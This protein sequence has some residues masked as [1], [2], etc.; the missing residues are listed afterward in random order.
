[1]QTNRIHDMYGTGKSPYEI[2]GVTLKSSVGELKRAYRAKA[3]ATHPDRNKSPN[4]GKEFIEITKAYEELSQRSEFKPDIRRFEKPICY[5]AN[6]TT[7]VHVGSE[8]LNIFLHDE[9]NIIIRGE[10]I[11]TYFN[12]KQI[13]LPLGNLID[14]VYL[15]VRYFS[16]RVELCPDSTREKWNLIWAHAFQ[17]ELY[18]PRNV[19][20]WLDLR[21][22]SWGTLNGEIGHKGYLQSFAAQEGTCWPGTCIPSINLNIAPNL[23]AQINVLQHTQKL[24][25]IKEL[26]NY[27]Y[28]PHNLSN[29][30]I[31]NIDFA[32][33]EKFKHLSLKP[34]PMQKSL[35]VCTK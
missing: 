6:P 16:E 17:G 13:K 28:N 23:A 31:M 20:L 3:L 34:S 33:P 12:P 7:I 15:G 32:D 21:I 29:P 8:K 2:L 30:K 35:E 19:D 18:L 4:A 22:H 5:E 26:S 1:M 11:G 9:P 25:E 14:E 27:C 10:S 24:G